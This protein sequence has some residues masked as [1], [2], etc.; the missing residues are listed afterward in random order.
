MDELLIQRAVGA[1]SKDEQLMNGSS[2]A[3]GL[4]LEEWVYGFLQGLLGLILKVDG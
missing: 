3:V 1:W 2:R 4:D